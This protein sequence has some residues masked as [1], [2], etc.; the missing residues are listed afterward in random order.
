MSHSFNF[1]SNGVLVPWDNKILSFLECRT[2]GCTVTPCLN[3]RGT[4]TSC[5]ARCSLKITGRTQKMVKLG[6]CSPDGPLHLPFGPRS[7]CY[8]EHVM[9]P[10]LFIILNSPLYAP[11]LLGFQ[12]L[13]L[14]A[15]AIT[16]S[17]SQMLHNPLKLHS[18]S[19][20]LKLWSLSASDVRR[21]AKSCFDLHK[22]CY[23]NP[24]HAINVK[25]RRVCRAKTFAIR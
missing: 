10:C 19:D 8:P 17:H 4:P 14:T 24:V 13:L 23:N 7:T 2:L 20:T 15:S 9:C 5:V 22:C 3:T 6:G 18:S 21:S 11:R 16:S 12:L 1:R 25:I